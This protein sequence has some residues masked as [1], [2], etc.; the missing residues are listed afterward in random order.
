[1]KEPSMSEL[2][3]F[4]GE[5]FRVVH[6]ELHSVHDAIGLKAARARGRKGGR[7]SSL[8]PKDIKTVRALLK[9]RELTVGDNAERIN[10]ARS[11]IY[12]RT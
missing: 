11:T 8:T 4:M 5:Q 1:M 10:V 9:T 2:M 3:T 12:N 7:R 6:D